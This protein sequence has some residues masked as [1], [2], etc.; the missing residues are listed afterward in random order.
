MSTKQADKIDEKLLLK[1]LRAFRKGDFSVRMP[2]DQT[3]IAGE[4]A[5]AFN[6]TVDLAKKLTGELAKTG[7]IVGKEGK[8]SRRAKLPDVHGCWSDCVDSINEVISD[9]V[10]PIMEITHVIGAV[11]K[12][13]LK[14]TIQ[15]EIEGRPLKGQYLNLAKII[16]TMVEQLGSFASEVTR[17]AREVGTEGILGGQA[18]VE[19]VSG[20]WREL[21]DN[22]NMMANNLTAQVRNIAEVTTAVAKGDLCS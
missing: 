15:I 6:D 12:G 4:I 3:G 21:T 5:E 18:K 13:D 19:G 20:T 8:I 17:V 7:K 9:M 2:S 1:S 16:N 14:K 11:A 10:Q 22:V